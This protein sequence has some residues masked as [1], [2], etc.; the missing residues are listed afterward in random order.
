MSPW[1]QRARSS[2]KVS[3]DRRLTFLILCEMLT[4]TAII[5]AA[6]MALGRLADDRGYMD[7][8]VFA[9]LVDIGQALAAS[10]EIQG[11]PVDAD[12]T[13]GATVRLRG[14]LRRYVRDWET[15]SSAAP[16]AVRLRDQ[17]THAGEANLLEQEH[18][19]VEEW[20]RALG[21]VE[22]SAGLAG[23]PAVDAAPSAADVAALNRALV[24]L[25]LINLRYVQLAYRSFE[26]THLLVTVFFFTI[27]ALGFAG[28]LLLGLSVRRAIA[29]RVQRMV[30]AVHRFRDEGSVLEL[31]DG[32]D[33]LGELARALTLSFRSILERDR[34][35][36]HFL[37]VA[38]HELKTPLSNLKGYAQAAIAH[39]D[40]SAMRARALTVIDRQATRLARLAQDLLWSVRADAGRL[41]FH[42]TPVDLVALAGRVITE[43]RVVSRDTFDLVSSGNA[44]VLGDVVLLEH[45][46]WNILCQAAT[47]NANG[48]PVQVSIDGTPSL[49]RIT[50]EVRTDLQIPENLDDLVEPF[51][52]L[53]F[54][55]GGDHLRGTGLGLHLVR[56]IARLHGAS[57]HLERRGSDHIAG[58]LEL[59]R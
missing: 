12:R 46:V 33:D 17:L 15:T 49:A 20:G 29:P 43:I 5:V 28:A 27:S 51:A 31:D 40:D 50:A 36:E 16:E 38:A 1:A 57:F 45:A 8:Y 6:A 54:E 14:Y 23:S 37:A 44:S 47:V 26:R 53:P 18:Q 9:P 55:R 4:A 13:R 58:V 19:M 59:R 32:P 39:P 22:R 35:R 7:R 52:S 25:N 41:P 48:A 56:D 2:A 3:V 30:Q 11:P 34:E 10:G 24:E 21:A 42:P